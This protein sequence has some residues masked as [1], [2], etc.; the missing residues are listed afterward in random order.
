[1]TD[2]AQQPVLRQFPFTREEYI[3]GQALVRTRAEAEDQAARLFDPRPDVIGITVMDGDYVLVALVSDELAERM[4][5]ARPRIAHLVRH[6]Q[7]NREE[8]LREFR[9]SLETSGA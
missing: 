6:A 3:A 8:F 2:T 5:A 9:R 7:A 1:M 4:M